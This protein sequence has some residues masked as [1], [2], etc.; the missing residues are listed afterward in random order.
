MLK[1]LYALQRLFQSEEED[2]T[3]KLAYIGLMIVSLIS[4]SLMID[5]LDLTC[6]V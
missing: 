6:R 5:I 3:M 2:E 4:E 1:F